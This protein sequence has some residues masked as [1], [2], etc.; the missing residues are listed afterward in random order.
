MKKWLLML[1]L[2]LMLGAAGCGNTKKTDNTA[3]NQQNTA[4]TAQ[5]GSGRQFMQGPEGELARAVMSITRI[6]RSETPFTKEQK[7]KLVAMLNDI[8]TKES[9]DE[10]YANK[11]VS[12][13]NAVFTEQQ[14]Q[15]LSQGPGNFN[16]NRGDANTNDGGQPPVNNG[17]QPRGTESGN[18]GNPQRDGAGF[19]LKSLC[20]RAISALQ[21]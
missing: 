14:K 15:V 13:I 6:Q 8:K 10:E 7:D 2:L 5:N 4:Q 9:V 21:E 3:D 20:E 19:D 11:K 18:N 12:E 16:R 17:G 1:T